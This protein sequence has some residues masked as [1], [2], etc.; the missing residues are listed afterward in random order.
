MTTI[1]LP[2]QI[3]H[4]CAY[5]LVKFHGIFHSDSVGQWI[6]L[7]RI[8]ISVVSAHFFS[9]RTRVVQQVLQLVLFL[10]LLGIVM[11]ILSS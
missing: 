3:F 11:F 9:V 1:F 7:I 5:I 4:I 6:S 2:F 10:T 8:F